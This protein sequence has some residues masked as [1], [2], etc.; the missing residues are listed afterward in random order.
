MSTD[1]AEE[2]TPYN[3]SSKALEMDFDV[4]A[5]NNWDKN[6]LADD[7]DIAVG[8]IHRQQG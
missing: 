7:P 1:G 5:R 3:G 6:L 4:L 2:R 8:H